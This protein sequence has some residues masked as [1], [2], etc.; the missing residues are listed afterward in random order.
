MEL[1]IDFAPA[2][3][4]IDGWENW[5]FCDSIGAEPSYR[6]VHPGLGFVVCVR[7]STVS[8]LD[9]LALAGCRPEDG[10]MLVGTDVE[11][12]VP[13]ETGVDYEVG[14]R[15]VSLERRTGRTLGEYDLLT[16]RLSLSRDGEEDFVYTGR[17][18]LPRGRR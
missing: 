5:L 4:R 1:P 10:P 14:H 2:T 16:H 6:R 18:A 8:I 11:I 3:T 9:L 17:M 7:A 13:L 15:F 12:R